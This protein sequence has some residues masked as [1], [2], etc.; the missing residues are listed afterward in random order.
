MCWQLYR[1]TLLNRKTHTA[2]NAASTRSTRSPSTRRVRIPPLLKAR[3]ATM[4]NKE[5]SEV[6]PSQ[7]SEKRQRPQRRL[8]LSLNATP[9]RFVDAKSLVDANHSFLE[10]KKTQ[11]VR[12]FSEQRFVESSR[13]PSWIDTLRMM[14]TVFTMYRRESNTTIWL[15]PKVVVSLL[16]SL[17]CVWNREWKICV[18]SVLSVI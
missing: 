3:D 13:W 1:C 5:V 17:N 4:Q 16:T 18:F 14:E 7:S 9:A 2:W 11:R 6:R 8:P 15:P 12:F 10:R